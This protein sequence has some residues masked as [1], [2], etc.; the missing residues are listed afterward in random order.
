MSYVTHFL[1]PEQLL[2][3]P[4]VRFYCGIQKHRTKEKYFVTENRD[5]VTC[6][7]CLERINNTVRALRA[8]GDLHLFRHHISFK[9]LPHLKIFASAQNVPGTNNW[10]FILYDDKSML[11]T[12]TYICYDM[13]SAVKVMLQLIEYQITKQP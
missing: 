10:N 6:T 11:E 9:P 4:Y 3:E 7:T 5:E 13:K 12:E 8:Y 1:H 2:G